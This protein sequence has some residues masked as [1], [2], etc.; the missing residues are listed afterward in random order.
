MF[1][2]QEK[3]HEFFKRKGNDL[4]MEKTL[5]L[6]EALCGFCFTF[7]HLDGRVVKC[8][9]KPGEVVKPEDIRVIQGEGMPVHGSPFTKGRLFVIFKVRA[10]VRWFV[11]GCR[12]GERLRWKQMPAPPST[13]T[14]E[15]PPHG[16]E[17]SRKH[18]VAPI[19][20]LYTGGVPRARVADAHAGQDPRGGAAPAHAAQAHGAYVRI[21]HFL[22]FGGGEGR[23]TDGTMDGWLG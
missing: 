8:E 10:G 23:L 22:V 14:R 19:P 3:E 12:G 11:G 5:S 18:A 13:S 17:P 6:T 4:F 2:V 9:S 7:T 21:P 1:L 16:T 15:M 20:F